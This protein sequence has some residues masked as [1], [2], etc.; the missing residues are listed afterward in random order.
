MER[1]FESWRMFEREEEVIQERSIMKEKYPFKAIYVVGPAGAGKSYLG[2][3]IG[4]PG[5][6]IT[7]NT[8]ARVENVF[9]AYN[10]P[11]TFAGHDPEKGE[12]PSDLEVLQQN[13]R[14][15][16]QNADAGHTTNLVL[17]G[18]PL[19]F[20]TTGENV[21]KISGRIQRLV[22]MG[23]DVA[24]FQ[25]T[26]PPS[27][28]VSRDVERGEEGGR[29]VGAKRVDKI[30]R[31]YQKAVV[32]DKGYEKKAQ[33][34]NKVAGGPYVTILGGG[35][36]PNIYALADFKGKKAGDLTVS[37]EEAKEVGL[38][39]FAKVKGMVAQAKKDLAGFLSGGNKNPKGQAMVAGM[40]AM[41]GAMGS[42]KLEGIPKG[43]SR[44]QSLKDLFVVRGTKWAQIPAIKKAIMAMGGDPGEQVTG[45]VR[46]KTGS[47][48]PGEPESIAQS[49][50]QR[51][52]KGLRP[53]MTKHQARGTDEY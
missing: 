40:K 27:V 36:I 12:K 38:P 50:A 34:I 39:S 46:G 29:S 45:A 4:I 43:F 1:L 17:K 2:S 23:Y 13:A 52:R 7:S 18:A 37:D 26:V 41:I 44:G 6:F 28:S 47:R 25:I 3:Q 10:I 35:V 20:D 16:L 49:T 9:R 33:E 21:T 5:D 14:H 11:L 8:D 51:G 22:D 19:L 15:I 48:Y 31:D 53:K 24:V 30:N 32:Q 42:E